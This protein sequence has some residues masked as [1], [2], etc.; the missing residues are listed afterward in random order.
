MLKKIYQK[1][2]TR[3]DRLKERHEAHKISAAHFYVSLVG[4]R[5]LIQLLILPHFLLLG[6]FK[7][8]TEFARKDEQGSWIDSYNDFIVANRISVTGIIAL[9]LIAIVAITV[10]IYLPIIYI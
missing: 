1:L 7:T 10:F 4:L 5:V 2:T 8:F 3:L 6:P 9:V